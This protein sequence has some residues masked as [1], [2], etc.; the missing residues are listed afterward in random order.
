MNRFFSAAALLGV[1]GAAQAHITLEQPSAD[2]GT[3]Y[4]A[5][6]RVGHG[7]EGS[8][9]QAITVTLPPGL[10]QAHPMPK[11]GWT[12]QTHTNAAGAVTQVV[13]RDGSL[14][15]AHYDEFVL[16]ARLPAQAGPLWFAVHQQC[17]SG[18]IDWAEVPAN[19]TDSRALKH[20]A[21]LLTVR[22]AAAPSGH[23]H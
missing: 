9:T 22:P 23:A 18:A 4:K 14:A 7:C 3:Y 17:A 16:R 20:P 21:A 13:W 12:L 11:P 2:A 5:V 15:D 8:P 6:L 1:A 19:G 10:E